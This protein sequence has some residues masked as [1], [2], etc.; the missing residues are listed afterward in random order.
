MPRDPL[1][2]PYAAKSAVSDAMARYQVSTCLLEH[3]PV[4]PYLSSEITPT[5]LAASISHVALI[6][7]N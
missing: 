5:Q 6:G 2:K 3:L 1:F 4:T 7:P